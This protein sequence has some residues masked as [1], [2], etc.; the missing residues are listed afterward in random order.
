M[1]IR[2]IFPKKNQ[3]GVEIEGL[4]VD[5]KIFWAGNPDKSKTYK[6]KEYKNKEFLTPKEAEI[7]LEIS[8]DFLSY[9]MQGEKEFP[10]LPYTW[11]KKC[12][13]T[14][15]FARVDLVKYWDML[16]KRK[17]NTKARPQKK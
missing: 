3:K 8:G 17:L 15:K 9:F 12:V 1:K 5:S 16:Q 13:S 14:V 4:V 7:F 2:K 11:D 6:R 10:K